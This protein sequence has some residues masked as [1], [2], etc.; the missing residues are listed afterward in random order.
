MAPHS[1]GSGT[2]VLFQANVFSLHYFN[3]MEREE[4]NW[5]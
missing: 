5:W 4:N 1:M 2:I 3:A